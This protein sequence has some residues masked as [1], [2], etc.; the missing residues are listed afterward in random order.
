MA[1][2]QKFDPFLNTEEVEESEE[3]LRLLD[4]DCR[5]IDEGHVRMLSPEQ[6]RTHFRRWLT[7]SSTTRKR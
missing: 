1:E 4:E 2:A 5:E 6:A 7:S 3:T